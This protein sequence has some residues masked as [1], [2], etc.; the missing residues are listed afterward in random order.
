MENGI[1]GVIDATHPHALEAT[2]NAREA[3]ERAFVPYLR[4]TREFV[5]IDGAGITVVGSCKEAAELL[6]EPARR[7]LK[8][9]L[10][11]GGKELARFTNVEDYRKRLFVRVLPV[12]EVL[13]SCEKM[14]FDA[15]HL[16]AMQGPFSRAMNEATLRMT[17]AGILVTKDSGAA[18]G[19]K[20][21]LEAARECGVEVLLVRRLEETGATVAEAVKW[22]REL[23]WSDDSRSFP[24]FPFFVNIVG[25]SVL[26]VGGGAVALRRVRTLL[27]CGAVVTVVSPEFHEDFD[28]LSRA[29]GENLRM[30]KRRYETR[31]FGGIFMAVP[32]TNDRELNRGIGERAREAGIPVSVADAPE[33]CSFFFPSLV[34]EGE[35]AVAVS[36]GGCPSLNRRLADRL[37]GVW[38]NWV[39]EAKRGGLKDS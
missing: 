36:A 23:L 11:V 38:R 24:L 13:W 15:G 31:D 9:L 7:G 28:A 3:C 21:K 30:I 35:V 22:G 12:G 14:G 2:R 6:N 4:V 33:E 25:R 39:E 34:T 16:I 19:L 29:R 1:S 5:N 20:E 32:A 26:V 8:V 10:A 37:R 18:G 17:D 27:A